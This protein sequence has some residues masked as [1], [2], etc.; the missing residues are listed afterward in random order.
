[1]VTKMTLGV[2]QDHIKLLEERVEEAK[3][4][5]VEAQ[6]RLWEI[7]RD[8]MHEDV[9]MSEINMASRTVVKHLKCRDCDTIAIFWP[10][11]AG[12]EDPIKF[13]Q[14]ECRE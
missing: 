12:Y 1:M 14:K 13:L 5:L 7:Q 10:Y 6:Q 2:L 11:H 3:T 8:C 4:D 9:V